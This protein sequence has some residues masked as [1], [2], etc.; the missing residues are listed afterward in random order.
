MIPQQMEARKKKYV[1]N[2][3]LPGPIPTEGGAER[4]ADAAPLKIPLNPPMPKGEF[5]SSQFTPTLTLPHQGGGEQRGSP[6]R[7]E[8]SFVIVGEVKDEWKRY[9]LC[10]MRDEVHRMVPT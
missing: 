9:A 3:C 8:G 7:E 10:S 2:T 1:G 4:N 5:L 6:I